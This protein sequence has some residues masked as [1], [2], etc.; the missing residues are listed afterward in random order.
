MTSAV[1]P[2]GELPT[3]DRLNERQFVIAIQRL[4][5][6][7][8]YGTD[9][10][11]FL[12][13]GLE[14]VQSRPYEPGDPIK[15]IDWRVT[16]RTGRFFIKEY[17]APKRMPVYFLIDTSASMTLSSRRLSKYAW[18]VQ[19]A[20]G[21]ALACLNRVSPVGVLGVGEREI[22]IQPSLSRDRVLQWLY[23]LRRFR[24][25]E[26]TTLSQRLSQLGPALPQRVAFI[27]LSD[28]HEPASWPALRLIAQRHETMVLQLQDPA[29]RPHEKHLSPGFFRATEAETGASFLSQGRRPVL[30]QDA[31]NGEMRRGGISH[32]L[33]PTDEPVV[34]KLRHFL[35]ARGQLGRGA[36]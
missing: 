30:D 13:S 14:Y 11:P 7:L 26:A 16:A 35:L 3:S 21:L 32:L 2:P 15:S 9:R 33:L 10:S 34:A 4:A 29:E 17:E 1:P 23:A 5:D 6:S 20:G 36:K 31:L 24:W 22:H 19:I 8:S 18:A 28:L 25:D 12:G 27:V